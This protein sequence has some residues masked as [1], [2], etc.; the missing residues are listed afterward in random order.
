M[1]HQQGLPWESG[2]VL[3]ARRFSGSSD[4]SG[5]QNGSKICPGNVSSLHHQ[6]GLNCF[7]PMG[8]VTV[9]GVP[10]GKIARWQT[11]QQM[12][13]F[14]CAGYSLPKQKIF[15][16]FLFF[17]KPR[18]VMAGFSCIWSDQG[19]QLR[20]KGT[21]T[22]S[23][24][25]TTIPST[26]GTCSRQGPWPAVFP[27]L[28][29]FLSDLFLLSVWVGLVFLCPTWAL[30]SSLIGWPEWKSILPTRHGAQ[31]ECCQEWLDVKAD[32]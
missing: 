15:L 3:G 5:E 29:S 24:P 28:S 20:K 19:R 4:G 7:D 25:V 10:S 30:Q 17:F 26:E 12:I 1:E 27:V 22:Q 16:F 23:K 18:E 32:F 2:L 21:A 6:A 13:E 14:Y 9:R 8:L 11:H 31:S